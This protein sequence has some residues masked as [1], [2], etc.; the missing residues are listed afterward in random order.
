MPWYM[1]ITNPPDV[2]VKEIRAQ[3]KEVLKS[4]AKYWHRRYLPKHFTTAG[5]AEY[6]YKP[7][8]RKYEI[9]KIKTAGHKRPLEFTGTLRKMVTGRRAEPT[10]TAKAV[11]LRIKVPRY[12]YFKRSGQPDKVEELLAMSQSE[13]DHG[14]TLI[15]EHIDKR[16]SALSVKRRIHVS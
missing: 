6:R 13:I 12:T 2:M 14:Q 15:R 16:L 7:R 1:E 11:S 9:R 3:A 8:S 4:L 5:A 10:G